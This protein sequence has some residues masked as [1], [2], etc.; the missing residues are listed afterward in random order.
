MGLSISLLGKGVPLI[1]SVCFFSFWNFQIKTWTM[2]RKQQSSSSW[3]RQLMTS[4]VTHRRELGSY[5]HGSPNNATLR[6]QSLAHSLSCT[7]L[8]R[9]DKLYWCFWLFLCYRYDNHREALLKGGLS[10]DYEDDSI[11]LLQYFTVTCYSG[12]GDDEK[13]YVGLIAC[14][15]KPSDYLTQFS[16][17]DQKYKNAYWKK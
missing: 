3:F 6:F 16:F 13:V 9:L 12:Y 14:C 17:F 1:Q 7:G 8:C 15:L 4:W 11:D 10:G 5:K 2:Q